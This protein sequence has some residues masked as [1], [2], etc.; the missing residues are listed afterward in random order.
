MKRI[1][2][3]FTFLLKKVFPIFWLSIL[4][5]IF[6]LVLS[7]EQNVESI[8]VGSF[9][10]FLMAIIG[11]FIYK[12]LLSNLIDEVYLHA[13]TLVFKNS[14]FQIKLGFDEI[15]DFN[16]QRYMNPH[17]VTIYTRNET[18]FGKQLCF[19]APTN[20]VPFKKNE[21]I[22]ELFNQLNVKP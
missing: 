21:D 20:Y 16:Y 17:K 9:M 7:Q 14:G 4:V 18:K 10:A 12:F 11:F 1:N 6:V 2:S 19:L 22:M 15:V 13:E 8:I 5:L 3:K